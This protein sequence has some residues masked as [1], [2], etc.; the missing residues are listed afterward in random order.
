MTMSAS[1]EPAAD[2][3]PPMGVEEP[4]P[5]QLAALFGALGDATCRVVLGT[6]REGDAPMTVQEL[7]TAADV[8]LTSTYRKLDQLVD[9]G[10]VERWH[11]LDE[12]GHRRSRF[13]PAVNQIEVKLGSADGPA[14]TLYHAATE[15]RAG[16]L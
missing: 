3:R 6:L 14:V 4:A 8:P 13:R 15:L 16:F 2:G 1:S 7:S 9:A 12:D 10:L 5:D 11:D